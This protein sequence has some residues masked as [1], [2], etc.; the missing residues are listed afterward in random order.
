MTVFVFAGLCFQV[1]CFD[2]HGNELPELSG[3]LCDVR[4][5]V[6]RRASVS[7]PFWLVSYSA[8]LASTR[9][10]PLARVNFACM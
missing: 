10:E 6:L 3:V 4:D 9:A 5:D 8:L 2:D 7:T 1:Q